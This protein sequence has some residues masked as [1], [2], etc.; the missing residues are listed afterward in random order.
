MA[1]PTL[2]GPAPGFRREPDYRIDLRPT[3]RR[4]HATAGGIVVVDSRDALL[5]IEQGLAPVWYFPRDDIRMDMLT[6]T[7]SATQCPFKGVASYWTL[8]SPAGRH[9][10]AAWAY[11][12]PFDEMAGIAGRLAFYW[13]ALDHWYE[14][15]AEIRGSPSISASR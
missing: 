8:S 13:D 11:E 10:D 9:E 14:D 15:E 3:G 4:V 7:E 2:P 6:P 12:A 1:Q 5:L